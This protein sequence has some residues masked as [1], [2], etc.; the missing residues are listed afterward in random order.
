MIGWGRGCTRGARGSMGGGADQEAARGAS[1]II[2]S[3]AACVG[4]NGI[5]VLTRG[6]VRGGLP[7]SLPVRTERER[8]E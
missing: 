4:G 6:L 1:G 3:N 2:N 8:M 5:V 7:E